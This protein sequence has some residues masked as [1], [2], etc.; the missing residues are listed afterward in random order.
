MT[1]VSPQKLRRGDQLAVLSPSFAAPSAGLAVHEQA[2]RRLRSEFSVEPVEFP[3]TR[4]PNATAE[5]RAADINAAFADPNIKGIITTVGG[6]D[7]ITVLRHLD[8][9]LVREHPKIFIGY[10]DNT[11]LHHF[12]W[13]LGIQSFYGGSTQVHIGAGPG[14]DEIHRKSLEAVLFSGDALELYEP[15]ESEDY[16]HFW[17]LPEA[18]THYGTRHAT[19][20]WTWA[21]PS[22]KVTGRTWGGCLE[23]LSGIALADRL[24][25]LAQLDGAILLLETSEELPRPSLVKQW[26]LG[27]G[28]RG[29]F[30]AVAGVVIARPPVT[31]FD[32]MLDFEAAEQERQHYEDT[33]LS[34][35]TQYSESL[36]ACF[37]VPFGHTR[38]QWIM[39]HGGVLTLDGTM[40]TV[41]ADYS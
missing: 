38:P 6:T 20:P 35:I 19:R 24:P 17:H 15:G 37:G 1:L 33:V 9:E 39:P 32:R 36:V 12:L 3:T 23:S 28:E 13:G 30:D 40:R 2:L 41:T 10:S 11:H 18:L 4:M 26:L 29:V 31:Y 8:M 7:E 27:L 5:Q 34:T 22:K 25:S 21:G 14:V 16:G